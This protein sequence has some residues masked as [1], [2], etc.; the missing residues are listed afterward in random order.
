MKRT[1][2]AMLGI[3]IFSAALT[4]AQTADAYDTKTTNDGLLDPS[5]FSIHHSVSFG[6]VGSSSSKVKSQSLYST[7]L[8][9]QFAAPVT[10]N[11]NFGFPLHSTFSQNANLSGENVSSMAYFESMP[12][13]FSLT[14]KPSNSMML[15][16]SMVRQP[17]EQSLWNSNSPFFRPNLMSPGW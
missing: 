9:Y 2:I 3:L 16:F 12:L 7:M 14:W 6:M 1:I 8:Q 13:D 10:V 11:L 17:A 5:R 15:R 4:S